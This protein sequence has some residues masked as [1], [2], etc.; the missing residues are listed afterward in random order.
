MNERFLCY[1]KDVVADHH[2][3]KTASLIPAIRRAWVLRCLSG[4]HGICRGLFILQPAVDINPSD[5]SRNTVERSW[6]VFVEERYEAIYS[7]AIY[8]VKLLYTD[9]I[10]TRIPHCASLFA[11]VSLGATMA[12]GAPSRSRGGIG[13]LSKYEHLSKIGEGTYG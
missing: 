10:T 5:A 4:G 12:N 7:C 2:T 1:A 13:Q 8:L 6:S 9:I 3:R 11:A